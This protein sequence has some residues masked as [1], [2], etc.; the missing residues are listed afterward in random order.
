MIKRSIRLGKIKLRAKRTFFVFLSTGYLIYKIFKRA[1]CT[2]LLILSYWSKSTYQ[3]ASDKIN[4][5]YVM[6]LSVSFISW[7]LILISYFNP[8]IFPHYPPASTNTIVSLN[9]LRARKLVITFKRR[10]L[11]MSFIISNS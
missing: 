8:M 6:R 10:Y 4:Y 7:L 3:F 5:W 11:N 2:G 9:I 1:K